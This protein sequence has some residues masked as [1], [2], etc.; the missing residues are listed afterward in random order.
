MGSNSGLF[1][2]KALILLSCQKS[3]TS[4]FLNSLNIRRSCNVVMKLYIDTVPL[5]EPYILL[6][7]KAFCFPSYFKMLTPGGRKGNS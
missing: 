7:C 6:N 4:P 1:V 2:K 5:G 3:L